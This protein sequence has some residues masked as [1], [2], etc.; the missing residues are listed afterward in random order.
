MSSGHVAVI[1]IGKTN[2]KLVLVNAVDLTELDITTIP[3]TVIDTKPWPHYDTEAIWTFLID[4]LRTFH[5]SHGIDVISI[6]THGACAALIAA[7]GTLAAPILDY[8]FDLDDTAEEY[9]RIRPTF[10]ETGSPR[11]PG[12]L[13]IGAQLHWQFSV[14]T[15]L[16]ARTRHIVT[17]PQYWAHRLT[18]VAATDVSSL[19]CHTDLWNPTERCFSTLVDTL[20]IKDKIAPVR[21]PSDVLGSLLPEIANLTGL[22]ESTP[23]HCGIHDSNASLLPHVLQ[24]TPP[25]SVV[26]TGTWVIAMSIGGSQVTLDSNKD[27]LINVNAMGDPVPSAR[28][29][30]GREYELA[31]QQSYPEPTEDALVAVLT[32]KLMLLPALMPNTGPYQ[33]KQSTWWQNNEPPVGSM[34]RG[35]AVALYLAL[36][37]SQCLELIGHKG[38]VIVEGPFSDNWVYLAML[39]ASTQSPVLSAVGMTGTSQ[40]A[41]LLTDIDRNRPV[42][43]NEIKPQNE[44]I[45]ELM[46]EYAKAWALVVQEGSG[47]PIR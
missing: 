12:G 7:D 2:A 28:F 33:G 35:A 4:G 39:R 5:A 14:D 30:G 8:E 47:N 16:Y 22:R 20:E 44:L 32:D 10:D 23:V 17:Y 27:T 31:T 36:V 45:S 40:G 46:R 38:A 42:N 26:S 6:T 18:G 29:M 11:L 15:N 41:A 43:C 25:F 34:Q 3:N 9:D 37:T 13:N 21:Q 1:D 24:H 19:G